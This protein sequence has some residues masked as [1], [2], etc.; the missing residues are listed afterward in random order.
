MQ[1]T[2]T[3]GENGVQAHRRQNPASLAALVAAFLLTLLFCGSAGAQVTT[4]PTIKL[5]GP[6]QKTNSFRG[7]VLNFTPVA[8]TVR[9][10]GNFAKVRTFSYTPEL[11]RKLENRRM[12]NGDPVTVHYLRGSDTA[13]RLKGKLRKTDEIPVLRK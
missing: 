13:V 11:T 3:S 10:R 12:E 2:A 5:K 8:I 1:G 6:K 7:E 4:L 9:D